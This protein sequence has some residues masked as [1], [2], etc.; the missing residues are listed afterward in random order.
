MVF[1]YKRS[2]F[3]DITCLYNLKKKKKK[4]PM[5]N[6]S[7]VLKLRN[8]CQSYALSVFVCGYGMWVCIQTVVYACV[9]DKES[10]PA[11]NI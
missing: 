11:G 2:K 9:K 4:K 1:I 6:L 3:S 5:H 10:R 7:V 8:S